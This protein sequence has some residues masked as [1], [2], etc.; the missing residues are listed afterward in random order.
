MPLLFAALIAAVMMSFSPN[1]AVAGAIPAQIGAVQASSLDATLLKA[2]YYGGGDYYGKKHDN[3]EAED[4]EEDYG[5][6]RH[7][8]SQGCCNNGCYKKKWVC[9]SAEPRCR[10]ER[11]CIWHYGKEY[12]RY[13]RRCY[14]D[15]GQYCKWISVKSNNCGW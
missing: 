8:K 10:K 13:V 15:S 4:E 12:C 3:Y 2:G 11:E 6:H 7:R 5:K 1:Q 9:E 14:G